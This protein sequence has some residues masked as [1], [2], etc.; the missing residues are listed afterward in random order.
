MASPQAYTINRHS[1]K[2]APGRLQSFCLFLCWPRFATASGAK[3]LLHCSPDPALLP[4][5]NLHYNSF[6]RAFARLLIHATLPLTF[7]LLGD[8]PLPAQRAPAASGARILLL[9]HKLVSGERA[10]LAVLDIGGRLTPG[11]IINFSNGDQVTTD[12]TGRALFVAPLNLAHISASIQGRSG[13]VTSTILAASDI[14]ANT[15]AVSEAP[16][17][18]SMADRFELYGHGFCGDADSNHVT[19]AGLPGLVLASSP[20]SLTVLPPTD[21]DAGPAEV[22]VSCGQKSSEP[23]TITFVSLELQASNAPLAPGERRML[24][25]RVRG[26]AAKVALE[27]H[28]LGADVAE[29]TGGAS[30]KATSTGGADNVAAFELV[31]K[32]HGAFTVSIRLLSPLSAPKL[33]R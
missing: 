6:V 15:E 28:N 1:P 32:K 18:A 22:T 4:G 23:F 30:V 9:P 26:T 8:T 2:A 31:G 17:I 25:V 29:L 20:G 33:E 7:L 16:R 10:T 14:P 13:R 5:G 27:A 12:A 24:T 11:V 3:P 19:I 21:M